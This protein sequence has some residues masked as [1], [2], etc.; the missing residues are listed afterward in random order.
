M[1][2]K[3]SGRYAV[4][5]M[6]DLASVTDNKATT[7]Q[8]IA[9]RQSIPLS[10]LEQIFAKLRLSGI[11]R[12]YKGPGGGYK[13]VRR[14]EEINVADILEAVDGSIKATLCDGNKNCMDGKKCS[15]HDLWS[16]LNIQVEEFLRGITL[17]TLIKDRVEKNDG[18]IIGK[19]N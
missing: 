12:S 9:E 8:M 1:R 4:A 19:A 15:S 10:Y 11:V 7:L 3:A 17:T 2:L 16:S 14:A 5:A 18:L 13:L 6:I